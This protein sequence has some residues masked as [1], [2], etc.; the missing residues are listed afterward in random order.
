VYSKSRCQIDTFHIADSK[1]QATL[2]ALALSVTDTILNARVRK[3]VHTCEDDSVLWK[4][5]VDCAVD[6]FSEIVYHLLQNRVAASVSSSHFVQLLQR[7]LRIGFGF[8]RCN[9]GSRNLRY[10][11][12]EVQMAQTSEYRTD[13]V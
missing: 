9:L 13:H 8:T 12:A 7:S 10:V 5:R 11:P 6:A 2:G 4:V 1:A 3:D